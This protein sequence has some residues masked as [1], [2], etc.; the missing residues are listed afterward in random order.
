MQDRREIGLLVQLY[1]VK[2]KLIISYESN[3]SY[4]VETKRDFTLE[5]EIYLS[6]MKATSKLI[7][8]KSKGC[9]RILP[10]IVRVFPIIVNY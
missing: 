5:S 3:T 6:L 7:N 4:D 9:T 8:P 10:T 2:K 1:L